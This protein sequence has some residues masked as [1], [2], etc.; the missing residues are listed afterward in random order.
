MN[1]AVEAMRMAY[2]D[3]VDVIWV[4]SGDGDFIELYQDLMK[5]GKQVCVAALS[6][7]LNAQVSFNVDRFF[8][9]DQYL[10]DT[11]KEDV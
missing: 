6:S 5:R 2:S 3:S 11:K 10:F 4:I 8:L 1:V 7:G 9:L